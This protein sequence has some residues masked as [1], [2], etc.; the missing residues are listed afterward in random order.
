MHEKD[1]G[2]WTWFLRYASE[3]TNRPSD[4]QAY[5]LQYCTSIGVEVKVIEIH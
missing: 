5:G 3:H 2:I 1:S 4:I